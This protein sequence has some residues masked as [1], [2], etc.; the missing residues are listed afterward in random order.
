MTCIGELAHG[1]AT[2]KGFVIDD[3]LL[4]SC[5]RHCRLCTFLCCFCQSHANPNKELFILKA[6]L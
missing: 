2:V 4:S 5:T 1:I 3:C 6:W